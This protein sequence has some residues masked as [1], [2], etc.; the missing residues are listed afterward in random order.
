[1]ITFDSGGTDAGS[2]LVAS[3]FVI[4]KLTISV[5]YFMVFPYFDSF[6]VTLRYQVGKS[7]DT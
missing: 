5:N 2:R 4:I 3:C 1:M 6:E 7:I